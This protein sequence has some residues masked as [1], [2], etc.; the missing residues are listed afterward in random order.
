[1]TN[2]CEQHPTIWTNFYMYIAFFFSIGFFF[3]LLLAPLFHSSL[4]PP[5]RTLSYTLFLLFSLHIPSQIYLPRAL[6]SY[7]VIMSLFPTTSVSRR[8]STYARSASSAY[9]YMYTY[10]H[11]HMCEYVWINVCSKGVCPFSN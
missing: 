2:E 5:S 11:K 8:E 7:R 6:I 4:I 9:I 1:M 3:L 10:S